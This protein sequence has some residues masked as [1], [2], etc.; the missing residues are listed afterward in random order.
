LDWVYEVEKFFGVDN[1]FEEKHVKFVTYK[2]KGGGNCMDG[3][4]AEY[5]KMARK[6]TCK[7]LVR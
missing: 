5:P 4:D 7:K 1:I 6:S 3:S 2:L